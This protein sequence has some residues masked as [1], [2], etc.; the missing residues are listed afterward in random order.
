MNFER[1]QIL[2]MMKP[3]TLELLK[4]LGFQDFHH[5]WKL[6]TYWCQFFLIK[7]N[8]IKT[9]VRAS[10]RHHS[11]HDTKNEVFHYGFLQ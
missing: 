5:S 7:F 6:Y 9:D 11:S 10:Y 1:V 3:V 4:K 8:H 2:A